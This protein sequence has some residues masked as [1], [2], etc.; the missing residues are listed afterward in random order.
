ML[1]GHRVI[2]PPVWQTL[3]VLL[4]DAC[5]VLASFFG[6][7]K[8]GPFTAKKKLA[9]KLPKEHDEYR[10]C[11]TTPAFPE[12]KIQTQAAQPLNLL[13]TCFSRITSELYKKESGNSQKFHPSRATLNSDTMTLRVVHGHHPD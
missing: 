3:S 7:V 10:R 2:N 5:Y 13:A 4:L 8:D 9:E 6:L 1:I 12:K 11:D